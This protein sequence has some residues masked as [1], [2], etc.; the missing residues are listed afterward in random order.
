[1]N[2]SL[3][4]NFFRPILYNS[5]VFLCLQTPEVYLKPN[6]ISLTGWSKKLTSKL[7]FTSSPNSNGFYRFIFHKVV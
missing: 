6:I 2:K 4:L 1:M 7:L 5:I 3:E